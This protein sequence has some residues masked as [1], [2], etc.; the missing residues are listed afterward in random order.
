MSTP[1]EDSAEPAER[2]HPWS[3]HVATISGIPLR[4]HITF[5]L[6]L[7]WIFLAGGRNLEVVVFMVLLFVCVALHEFGHALVAKRYGVKT[8][9]ITLYPIGGVAMLQG[10]PKPHQEFWIALAGPVVNVVI[11]IGLG[12]Y[13]FATRQH[14]PRFGIG[15]DPN[16]TL[17]ENLYLANIVLPLFNMIPAFPMDGGR[18]LRAFLGFFMPEVRSTRIAAGIGQLL[19]FGFGFYGLLQQPP[20]IL[21]IVIAF[22]VFMGASQEVQTTVGLS[23]VAGKRVRDA[24]QVR[25]RTMPSGSS[26]EEAAQALLSGSQHDFPIVAGEEV[27]G[28]LSRTDIARGL[29]TEGASGYVAGH[30]TRELRTISP[31]EALEAAFEAFSENEGKPLLVMDGETLVGMLTQEN[32]S[33]FLMLQNARTQQTGKTA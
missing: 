11:A 25:Y 17:L 7:A 14:L 23:L 3:M 9:D 1:R 8:R 29:A 20:Q 16:G 15:L 18:V 27:I 10:R 21:L 19:A 22:F 24:M 2:P 4:V 26:M 6:L 30:M 31:D 13:L 28:L 32:F 12:A 33:E 5:P